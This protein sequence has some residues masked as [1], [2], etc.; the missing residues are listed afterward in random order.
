[1]SAILCSL[2]FFA[3]SP[4]VLALAVACVCVIIAVPYASSRG[5]L[6]IPG[7][8]GLALASFVAAFILGKISG[9]R[10]IHG[11]HTGQGLAVACFLLAAVAV[12]SVLGIFFHREPPQE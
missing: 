4:L 8:V 12:G 5:Q 6:H 10:S 3:A 9:H 2:E 11:T 7:Y 1:M